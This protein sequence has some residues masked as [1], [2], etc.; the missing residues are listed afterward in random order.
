MSDEASEDFA[1]MF[2]SEQTGPAL[3]VG[4]VVKGRVIQITAE[5]VFVDVGGKGEAWIDRAELTDDDGQLRV[6]V[7]DE[8]EATVVSTR[9]EIR[10]SYRLQR[11][12]QAREAL[13]AAAASGIPVEGKVAAVIKGGYEVTVA[14]HRTF[15]PF[16]Q[17]DLRRTESPEDYVGRVLEFRINRYAENGRNIVLSR[18][19]LLE[20]RAAKDAEETRR[21]IVPG[22]VLPGTVVSLADF[23]AFID[24]GGVQGL[25]PMSELSHTRVARPGDRLRVGET[26]TVKVLKVDEDKGRISLSLKALEGD[27]WAAMPGRLRERQ[28]VRGR[29]VRATEFGIFVELL[30]GIDGLLHVSEIPRSR[31]GA[32]R[33]A[34]AA[35]AEVSVMILA[36]DTGKRRVS[37]ALAPDDASAG[38]R[39]ESAV[40]VGAVLTGTV[41]RIEPFGVFVR[42]G[43]G[44]T[45]VVPNAELGT[46]RG[47]DHRKA[48]PLGSELKVLVLSIEEGGRRI[49]LSHAQ[50]LAHDEHAEAEAYRAET[51]TKG[52]GFGLTL[53]ELFR[54]A[55]RT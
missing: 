26:V 45:G 28:V 52:G 19:Q 17:M 11:G 36:I 18:R 16:S 42:L 53:G 27:P 9:D 14:G 39:V 46:R 15:C 33:E 31:A 4:Q 55:R 54:Q 43:P 21:K 50:A 29:L 25:V 37:L 38:D 49:R 10:L 22:A 13:A 8:V 3:E 30:P 44:Q 24:L 5:H 48:F 51:E 47:A 12:A 34:V 6:G 7:G 40:A 23:G 20:E 41:E 2:A 32:M 35:R 1:A